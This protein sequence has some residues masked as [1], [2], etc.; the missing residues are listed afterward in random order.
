MTSQL[1]KG[2]SLALLFTLGTVLSVLASTATVT[3]TADS[4][5]GTLRAAASDPSVDEIRFAAS[6]DGQM[7]VLSRPIVINRALDI[8]GN[9]TGAT[10]IS[11]GND[12]GLYIQNASRVR[13]FDLAI[14]G[15]RGEVGAA[16]I[17]VRSGLQVFSCSF[18]NNVATGSEIFLGGAAI[19][20]QGGGSLLV[21]DSR[22]IN[23]RAEGVP[24][25]G[26]AIL[27]QT[28]VVVRIVRSDFIGN[29]SGGTG[30]AIAAQDNIKL[31]VQASNFDRNGTR[32]NDETGLGGAIAIRA[33]QPA[34]INGGVMSGN[35]GLSSG[36]AI[37]STRGDV[38][39]S[40]VV[41]RSNVASGKTVG[42]GGA[43]IYVRQGRLRVTGATQFVDNQANGRATSGGGILA[44][45][46]AQLEIFGA[47]FDGNSATR[48][49]GAIEDAS[50]TAAVSR[51]Y[52]VS[53][54]RNRTGSSPGNGGAL[55]VTGAGDVEVLGGMV[56]DNFAT[57]EGGG[58][59]NGTGTMLI[60]NVL[61]GRNRAGGGVL[62]Q[63]G[64]GVFNNGGTV[65][66]EINTRILNNAAY[67]FPAG[68]GGGILSVAGGSVHADRTVISGNTAVRAGGGI[69]DASGTGNTR[70][71]TV[72]MNG[73]RATASPGSG[74]AVHVTG[75]A[76]VV[77]TESNFAG[78]MARNEGGALWNGNGRMEV[79]GST[80]TN[81]VAMGNGATNGGGGIYNA[82]GMLVLNSN[83]TVSDN[84]AT[85]T[86]GSG[87]GIFNAMGGTLAIFGG[88]ITG[89]EANRAGGGIEDASMSGTLTQI[90]GVTLSNNIV[91]NAPGNGG[92]FHAT[93]NGDVVIKASTV[94]NNS[95]GSE[96]GG[97]WNGTGTMT[98]GQTQFTGNTA[99]GNGP[100]NGGGAIYNAGGTLDLSSVNTFDNNLATGTSG[101][102]GAVFNGGTA[103]VIGA[104]FNNNDASR[105]GGA[106]EDAGN[107]SLTISD[108]TFNNNS[109]AANPGNGGAVHV[110][111][112]AAV[113][114][115][116]SRFMDNFAASE[117]GGF[118]NGTGTATVTKTSFMRNSADG[119]MADNGGGAI[120]SLSGPVNIDRVT[121]TSNTAT[122]AS[123]SGG[124]ILFDTN[125]GGSI[126]NSTFSQN[127]ASRAGGAIEDNS[128][129]GLM[130]T[131]ND[132]DFDG[133]T[134][135]SAPGN[136]GA[137]H[138]TGAGNMNITGGTVV[139]NTAANEGGGLWN[140]SG[141]M[142]VTQVTIR[143]NTAAGATA[144][145][146][147]G[148][149]F[150]NG[151]TL[152]VSR[153]LI[154]ANA[155]NGAAGLGGGLHNAMGGTVNV[156]YSTVS[157]NT[158]AAGAGG[159]ASYSTMNVRWST[160]ATNSAQVG[161]GIAIAGGTTT[162]QSSI[163][164]Q[165]TAPVGMDLAAVAGTYASAGFNAVGMDDTNVFPATGSDK[166]GTAGSPL[167]LNLQPLAN[168]GG[169]T[170]THALGCG[171]V[172]IDM[173]DGT[174]AADQRG[175]PV[176]NQRDIGAFELQ[177]SCSTNPAPTA[178][179]KTFDVY[180][181][182]TYSNVTLELTQ[183]GAEAKAASDIYTYQIIGAG[184]ELLR[185]IES[186]SERLD[187][188]V[189][190]LQPGSYFVQRLAEDGSV[191]SRSFQVLR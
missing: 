157:G 188:N 72:I 29:R 10:I 26:G 142:N 64:G 21:Q 19:N 14:N 145:N 75:D 100:T 113:T 132:S 43:G 99:S 174:G 97:L 111:G 82:G 88:T 91:N 98:V 58:L 89:N 76:D 146:G 24:S 152:T 9:G 35:F 37:Y 66:I 48:A 32:N 33:S 61:I 45:P 171:S 40:N 144:M 78:N 173:G 1:Y 107:A 16:I 92:G 177:R 112:S 28:S 81:N 77:I 104:A 25:S 101:S 129:G 150:N 175:F 103:V 110:T 18:A 166:E 169:P 83:S 53:M 95:A 121:F 57:S 84:R 185:V 127:T 117:G 108:V 161:G 49:G 86:S 163:V 183:E 134:T 11:G 6:T 3:S 46:D 80:I 148:G 119:D 70:L 137:V 62:G 122:G 139:N 96:G 160:I 156:E 167:T 34:S 22:F 79:S 74:G 47:S 56:T 93:G 90:F 118:W 116:D 2:A 39:V 149:I 190:D 42:E 109:A 164:A 141:V 50:G 180:P 126:V 71:S 4:G 130:I 124:A 115:R 138:I 140:G 31:T 178:T 172:A 20:S 12:R 51:L 44:G 59:W 54:M 155:S 162:L 131:V 87:G 133:N 151:G 30:G 55:H 69:E 168:N 125:S 27:A 17:S 181:T 176:F 170:M 68:S 159:L 65:D 67:G 165:N 85:G 187:L 182:Q 36:G 154:A 186:A 15:S 8:Y 23:N 5:P 128:R 179:V 38:T 135:G 147:G 60:A 52:S 191:E 189:A 7:I 153:S 158:S 136:G 73:N 123:G 106:I 13:L 105:A 143:N 120:Y 94:E 41:F 102:G 114:I 63:G 184:G